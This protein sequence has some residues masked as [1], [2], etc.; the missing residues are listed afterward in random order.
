MS[1]DGS[2]YPANKRIARGFWYAIAGTTG[3]MA[4]VRAVTAAQARQRLQQTGKCPSRPRGWAAQMLATAT[5]MV[6]EIAYP[7]PVCFTG[8]ISRYFTP[9]PLGRWIVLLIYWVMI[10]A[11]L[12]SNVIMKPS[13]PMAGYKWEKVGYRAAWVSITQV[14]L[15]YLLA[16]KLNPF[17]LITGIS[18]ERLNWLHRWTARTIFLT[19]IVHWAFFLHEWWLADFIAEELKMMPVVKYGI[20]AFGVL[21][22]MVLSS[23]GLFRSKLYEVWVLQHIAAAAVFLWLLWKH[24]PSKARY[25]IWMCVGFAAFD[26][27]GRIIWNTFRNIRIRTLRLGYETQLE[28]LPGDVVRVTIAEPGFRWRA[29]QHIYLSIPRLGPLQ[30]HPF[31]IAGSD[32]LVLIIQARSGFSR[33]LLNAAQ[34]EKRQSYRALISGP[35]GNP[36]NFRHFDTVVLLA[37][38]TGATFTVPILESLFSSPTCVRRVEFHWIVRD[39]AHVDWFYKRLQALSDRPEVRIVIHVTGSVVETP[40]TSSSTPSNASNEKAPLSPP[41]RRV[42]D[43]LFVSRGSRPELDSILRGPIERALGETAVVVCGNASLTASTRTYISQL[44]DERAVH[45]GSGAQGI[46]VYCEAFSSS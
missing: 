5:A 1:G 14:P 29:G 11:M 16:F 18:Y 21:C 34:R 24:V 32:D 17:S 40:S 38:S 9:L 4:V 46:K 31:T 42:S 20:G 23:F 33:R 19:V 22:W 35:W 2:M 15:I 37:A 26:W 30:A 3:L 43:A 8:K 13:D 6:R 45:K 41:P 39:T 12:W 7:Q 44:S 27:I 36:P 25:N 10:L 28:P